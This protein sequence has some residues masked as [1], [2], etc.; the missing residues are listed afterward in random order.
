MKRIANM[1]GCLPT[2]FIVVDGDARG[3]SGSIC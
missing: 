2:M 1:L 3:G